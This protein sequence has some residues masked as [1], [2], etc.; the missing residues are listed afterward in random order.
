MR[1]ASFTALAVL[2]VAVPS[3]S[4]AANHPKPRPSP[5]PCAVPK[6]WNVVVQDS[7]ALVSHRRV[8]GLYGPTDAWQYCPRPGSGAVGAGHFRF[9]VKP[10]GC[11]P[12]SANPTQ[13]PS[14]VYA[15]T[16]SGP[17]IA[18]YAVWGSRGNGNDYEQVR[19]VNT[20]TAQV[21]APPQ[22]FA[23][24]AAPDLHTL[25]LSSIGVV[26]WLWTTY[27]YTGG[28]FGYVQDQLQSFDSSTGQTEMLDSANPDGLANL[29]L[30]QCEAGSGCSSAPVIVRW[31]NDGTAHEAAVS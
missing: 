3:A 15:L 4:A 8:P 11:C 5:K 16:L 21:S 9:L 19:V 27:G 28:K 26:V 17:Y 29:Q 23:Q 10:Q 2:A 31:T 7:E 25:L 1:R 22:T 24:F 6:G 13:A 20:R 12:E 30:F 14:G 18:Y